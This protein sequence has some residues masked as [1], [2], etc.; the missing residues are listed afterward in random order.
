[1]FKLIENSIVIIVYV[2]LTCIVNSSNVKNYKNNFKK[3]EKFSL[4]HIFLHFVAFFELKNHCKF[5][6]FFCDPSF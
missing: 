3:I 4:N 2:K 6:L 1:M 5:V